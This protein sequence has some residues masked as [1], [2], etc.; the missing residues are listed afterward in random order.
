MPLTPLHPGPAL[1]L[2]GLF[3]KILNLWALF[4]GSVVMDIEP[5][6]GII[7]T[8]YSYHGFF[9]TI[10]GAISGS[11]L[12]AV[13]LWQFRKELNS[14]SLKLRLRQTFSF[15]V[16][17]FSTLVAWLIH[18]FFDS[19]SHVDVL[20]FWPSEHNPILIGHTTY[21]PSSLILLILL[22]IGLIIIIK[23]RQS[24]A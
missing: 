15:P 4:L 21:W 16:L 12:V 14:I 13:I 17:F 19:L 23:K 11:L 24:Y 7:F 6:V 2:G 8:G 5:V 9:H 3:P 1:I 10:L 18:I 20:P 22:I